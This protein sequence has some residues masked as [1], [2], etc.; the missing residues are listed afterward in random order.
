M[1]TR[2]PRIPLPPRPASSI[3]LASTSGALTTRGW[4]KRSGEHRHLHTRGENCRRDEVPEVVHGHLLEP[5]APSPLSCATPR[6]SDRRGLE[7]VG[8][9]PTG[10]AYAGRLPAAVPRSVWRRRHSIT[11]PPSDDAQ[12]VRERRTHAERTDIQ[13]SAP[14]QADQTME[15]RAERLGAPEVDIGSGWSL[16]SGS[17]RAPRRSTVP[18]AM[19]LSHNGVANRRAGVSSDAVRGHPRVAEGGTGS[20]RTR[21]G[22]A[23]RPHG[24]VQHPPPADS[25]ALPGAASVPNPCALRRH[26]SPQSWLD[27]PLFSRLLN[28]ERAGPGNERRLLASFPTHSRRRRAVSGRSMG[29]FDAGD[30]HPEPSIC[31]VRASCIRDTG[32]AHRPI[33]QLLCNV[34]IS[35]LANG[36]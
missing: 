17:A 31:R 35:S 36:R 29:R 5:V 4:P 16:W 1:S 13:L 28:P 21:R 30:Q 27:G 32:A 33:A 10:P 3:M 20:A 7:A 23:A 18:R 34:G 8:R 2:W 25:G 26:E 22:R 12:R 11:L 15:S 19:R 14:E 9:V 6:R 24:L